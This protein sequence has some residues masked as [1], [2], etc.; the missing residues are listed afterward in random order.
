MNDCI[1]CKIAAKK[2]PSDIVYEDPDVIAF[3]DIAPQAPCHFIVIPRKHYPT[4]EG[5]DAQLMGK[6][7]YAAHQIAQDESLLPQGYRIVI[8]NGDH[9]GQSVFHLH[10]HL[11]G[12]RHLGWPPG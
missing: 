8:N 6:L 5:M 1:F 3:C 12:G 7:L 2:I 10:L 11:L 4:L 9:G